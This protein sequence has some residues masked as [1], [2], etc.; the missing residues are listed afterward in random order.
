MN[1]MAEQRYLKLTVAY[2]GTAYHGFQRQANAITVQQVLEER[3][4]TIFG[5]PLKVTGAARTDAGV[6]AYGQVVGFATSGTIPAANI[7]RAAK[8]V[9]PPDIVV[10]KAE[11]VSA[12]FHARFSARSKIYLYR[13]YN[14]AVADP[15]RRNYAWHVTQPLDEAAMDTAVQTVVGTH[16]FSAFRAAGG[17]PVSPVRTIYEAGC[18][19]EGDMLEFRFWGNGFLYHMVRNL[20]GTL[21]DVGLGRLTRDGFTRIL[22]GR[23]RTRAGITAPPQGLYLKEIFY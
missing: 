13:I 9:L 21:V 5:H 3:L 18:T 16:D 11:E 12:D 1:D 7:V 23:D 20:V 2:D 15:F 17:P 4:A 10:V 19:R 8:S 6:H 22:A 14:A